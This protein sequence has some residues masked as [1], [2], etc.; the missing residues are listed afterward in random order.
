MISLSNRYLQAV[1][2][3]CVC[4][5]TCSI[6]RFLIHYAGVAG[7]V[8]FWNASRP[9]SLL[10]QLR[11]RPMAFQ[12]QTPYEFIAERDRCASRHEI[13]YVKLIALPSAKKCCV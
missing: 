5:T 1:L 4:F 3:L 2:C 10:L 13:S 12:G 11:I 8:P 9:P 7:Y 6:F